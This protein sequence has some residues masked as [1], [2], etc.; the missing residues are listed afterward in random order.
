[1]AVN[2]IPIQNLYYLLCYSW[3]CLEESDL[4]H[5]ST[6]EFPDSH[7]FF[8]MVL[9]SAVERLFRKGL[10]R[11]YLVSCEH[12][13]RLRGRLSMSKTI[14]DLS[15]LHGK[16]HCEVDELQTNTI[17]N[18][19]ICSTLAHLRNSLTSEGL[20]KRF[21]VVNRRMGQ[22]AKINC[23]PHIWSQLRRT[24]MSRF[25]R[26]I[27]NICEI[28]W[29]S[30][31]PKDGGEEVLFQSF[32]RDERQMAR[33][34]ESFVRNFY[35]REQRVYPLVSSEIIDWD[36]YA[37]KEEDGFYLPSMRTDIS[38]SNANKKV[39]VETKYYPEALRVR[40][41][42]EKVISPHLYQLF[43]YLKNS[44]RSE[45]KPVEGIL[46]YPTVVKELDLAYSMSG[47]LL[48]VCTINLNSPWR[49]IHQGL[50][51]MIAERGE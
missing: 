42:R 47:N 6:E 3:D 22:I 16:A 14:N 34:F 46:L 8:G 31:L 9:V 41:D 27:L 7:D 21:S 49:D 39:I 44:G 13:S 15:F 5:S 2:S 48:R 30:L 10:K 50:L 36:G 1:M 24:R 18:Q 45:G 37:L 28:I 4:L 32:V 38:L 43:A 29:S 20:K 40:Y 33:L 35:R 11:E 23:H 51:R 12:S 25:Y 19:V 26:F 17:A